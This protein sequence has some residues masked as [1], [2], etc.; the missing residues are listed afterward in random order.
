MPSPRFLR[1][2]ASLP[3][4]AGAVS[5][6]MRLRAAERQRAAEPVAPVRP[7]MPAAEFRRGALPS[8]W[9]RATSGGEA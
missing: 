3:A 6:R 5:A 9:S 7:V 2:A 8:Q 4:Y 1:L